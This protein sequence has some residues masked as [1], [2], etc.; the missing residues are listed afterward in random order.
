[1]SIL[2]KFVCDR[3]ALVPFFLGIDGGG[4]K[5]ACLAGDEMSVLGSGTAG[6]SN[7]VRVGEV[8]ARES[9]TAAIRQSCTVAGVDPAQLERTYV[10]IAGA[11]QSEI[12]EAVERIV[13]EIVSGEVKVVGDMEIALEAAFGGGPGV[14]V[15]AGTG[16]IA[17]GRNPQGTTTRAG[18]WGYAISDEGSGY[19]IGRRAVS[20]ALRAYDGSQEG[21]PPLLR[22]ILN[23]WRLENREQL[24]LKANAT[25]APDF[26]VLFPHLVAAA[27]SGEPLARNVLGQAG[28]ELAA[29]GKLVMHQL[30]PH[31]GRVPVAMSGGVF[32]HS[33]LV[34]QIFYNNLRSEYPD[35]TLN[36][37]VVEPVRGALELARKAVRASPETAV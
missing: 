32:R 5:T 1:M 24:V 35:S 21:E 2:E 26:A 16:S 33:A 31:G 37:T 11:A 25:P 28:A 4:S 30:F 15:I 17:Y 6:P 8:R 14:I 20:S 36:P 13:S 7:I 29:L 12:S 3:T 10:G 19:W 18:G 23:A 9:L 22:K 34:R 27:D